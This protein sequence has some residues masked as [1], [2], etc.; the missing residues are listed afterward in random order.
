[1]A[2][3]KKAAPAKRA[4]PKEPPVRLVPNGDG[5]LR[6]SWPV[7]AYR[8]LFA[9]GTVLNVE[10]VRDDSVLRGALIDHRKVPDDRIVGSTVLGCVGWTEVP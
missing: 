7:H 1:M 3:T 5:T 4:A 2:T 6:A 10:S 9:D 8:F